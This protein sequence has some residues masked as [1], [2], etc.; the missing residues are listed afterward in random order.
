M[1]VIPA[2]DIRGGRCVRLYQGDYG[3]ETVFSDSPLEMASHW[4]AQGA[5]RLHVVDLD[6]ARTGTQTNISV[7]RD[8]AAA[9]PAPVQMGGG[10]RTLG[11]ARHAL[12]LG[13]SR[14]VFGTAVVA[15]P[16]QVE[17]AISELGAEAVMASVDARDGYVSTNGWTKNSRAPVAEVVR[18]IEAMGLQRFVYTDVARDGTLGEPNFSAIEGLLS[19]TDLKIVVAGGISTIGHI[20]TLAGLG[21]EAAIVGTAVYTDDID[22]GEAIEAVNGNS[23]NHQLGV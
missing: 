8:I 15:E 19:Q 7:I 20:H 2:I 18:E 14:V 16:E 12:N 21:V 22:L 23:I 13:V 3:R 11:S 4:I 9:V 6:G 1:E 10:I 17:A 5:S